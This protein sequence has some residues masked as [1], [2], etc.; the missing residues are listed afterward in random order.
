MVK[1]LGTLTI[2]LIIR[3]L[4]ERISKNVTTLCEGDIIRQMRKSDT[5]L[6]ILL[7]HNVIMSNI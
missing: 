3:Y 6:H 5:Q 1:H 4:G 7:T 2:L